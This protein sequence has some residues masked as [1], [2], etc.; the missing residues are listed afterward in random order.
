MSSEDFFQLFGWRKGPAH[1]QGNVKMTPEV[2]SRITAA[3]NRSRG[4]RRSALTIPLDAL[5]A[6]GVNST[7]ELVLEVQKGKLIL[8]PRSYEA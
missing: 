2:V 6:I 7:G 1:V 8:R 5:R 3:L 4:R